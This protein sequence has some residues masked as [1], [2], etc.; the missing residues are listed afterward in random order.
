MNLGKNVI[1]KDEF[2]RLLLTGN[3]YHIINHASLLPLAASISRTK[4]IT[5]VYNVFSSGAK[6]FISLDG[7]WSSYYL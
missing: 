7:L 2:I 5:Q 6:A 3:D 4:C 1:S